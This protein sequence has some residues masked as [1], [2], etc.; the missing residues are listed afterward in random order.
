MSLNS[1]VLRR[2]R[3]TS[4]A[5]EAPLR[6]SRSDGPVR[7]FLWLLDTPLGLALMFAVALAVR[8]A[9]A[10]KYGFHGDL[11]LFQL[12]AIGLH[13]VGIRHFYVGYMQSNTTFVYPPGYLYILDVIAKISRVPDYRL[14]KLPAILG[15]LGLAW[16]AGVFALR[17]APEDLRRRLPVRGLVIA[18]VLFNPAVFALS[19]MWGQV[20]AVP[21]VFA[22][23]AL[24]L[25]LTG[26]H[27]VGR[28]T[29]AMVMFAIAFSM[30]PQSS[31]LAPVLAYALYRRY[32]YRRGRADQLRG[33][34]KVA[35]V[36][37]VGAVLWAVS[38]IPFGLSPSGLLSFYSKASN[39]Y[40]ITS[41]WAFNLWGVIGFQRGDVRSAPAL[42][43]YVAGIPA[44][45]VGAI[46][47]VAGT[48]YVLWRTH[49]SLNRGHDEARV[50]VVAAAMTSLLAFTLLTR[51]HERYLF[52]VI[53]GLAPLVLWRGFRR[54]YVVVS[55]LFILNLWYPFAVYNRSW[56]V[57]TLQFGRVFNW[58]FGNIDTTDTWQKKMWSVFMVAACVALVARG[59]RWIE[60]VDGDADAVDRA[61]AP[62][63]APAA[64]T[65]AAAGTG[66]GATGGG[67]GGGET[68]ETGETGD[69]GDT[70]G[71]SATSAA[72]DVASWLRL[73]RAGVRP[74]AEPSEPEPTRR[75]LR[76]L[77]LSLVIVSCVFSLVILRSETTPANNLNDSAFHLEMVRWASHQI[78]EG[79][80]PLDGWFPDLSLGSSFFHHY[81]SLP[82]T[83]T[84]YAA[85]IS[86]FDLTSTYLW[87]LYLML[88]L[89][90]ISVY[91]GARL[92]SLERW[93]A[94]AAALV[95]PLIVSIT[96][97]GYEHGSYTWQGLGVYTQLFG[98]W[99]LPLVWGLTWRAVNK[100]GKWY[101]PAAG[102]LALTIATHLMTGYLAVL[103]IG[104]WVLLARR[105]FFR[106]IGRAAVVA[107]GGL[108]TAA[109]V[110]VPLLADRNYAAQSELYKGK[111]FDDSYGAAKI[112]PWLFRGELFDHG[113]FPIFSLLLA[114]GFVVCVLRAQR[115]EAARAL[116][117]IWTFSLLLFFGRATW[118]VRSVVNLLPGNGDLQMHRFMSGVDLAGIFFAG[119]GLV[120]LA[121]LAGFALT[122]GIGL[123]QRSAAKPI[124]VW[125]AVTVAFVGILAPAWTERAHYDLR[126]S[127]FIPDQRKYEETDGV[128][129]AK[130]V[131]E[132]EKL[133]GGRIYAGTRAN[134]GSYYTIGS[135]QGFAEVEDY[136]A[137]SIGYP[138]RTVQSLSTDVD[139]TFADGDP[140]QYQIMNMMY[141]ILP[142]TMSPPVPATLLDSQGRHR[143]Y[144]VDTSGYFQ[145][146]DVMGSETSN[147]TD[148]GSESYNFRYSDLAMH[149]E[150]PSV[151][152]NGA[153]AAPPTV[154]GDVQPAGSPG[155]VI[156]Q[157]NDKENGLFYATVQ[158]NRTAGVLLK[159]SF[160]PRWTVTVDGI[161]QKPVMIAP[162]L[163]GVEV[164]AGRHVI[165]FHYKSYSH[166]PILV[167]IGGLTLLGLVLWPRRKR[168]L[169]R[170]RA[171]TDPGIGAGDRPGEPEVP[172]HDLVGDPGASP[173]SARE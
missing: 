137:D 2:R 25:L 19:T 154:S 5:P 22:L 146:I 130:L 29:F 84:A 67:G 139:A 97:Y 161:K 57:A 64:M 105:G 41:V 124:V 167:T 15:D 164:P 163:V 152:F 157:G 76:L 133:G 103:S 68:G 50:M 52:P 45:Y 16:L 44:F 36:G 169:G 115:S 92:L 32:L 48:A 23:A 104:V 65:A 138:F 89:W 131:K 86:P 158:A 94:A 38:G 31:F 136:D 46:A 17:L 160:D 95:S 54:V 120:A 47:F 61:P 172:T 123:I 114:V 111:F 18:A 13:D 153:P 75:W 126:D 83:L 49:L 117:G 27:S 21:A 33:L 171:S 135:V 156:K 11:N 10:Q 6:S 107:I 56:G 26:R 81:Q 60:R 59:F 79:R 166:Y 34:G 53:V 24:L 147:R 72:R 71:A 113:R 9:L 132:A 170:F 88:A 127:T 93:P 87:I 112:L 37:A 141:M 51:M 102:V 151:A 144:K 99:L 134:W 100:G 62:V 55:A 140:A 91:L 162:S 85:R 96:G 142:E 149:N 119:V 122:K 28:D 145:V 148:I 143:L 78:S 80:I 82:Y 125:T 58:V 116:L 35:C 109:W 106:R 101:A 155:T 39:G 128:G 30:K 150:Y 73:L 66:L 173:H 110:L 118:G 40:K 70:G 20:D 74:I 8:L 121:R 165:A 129:F 98:M 77:P 108:V 69:T 4:G 1:P 14:M 42:V 12:W 168:L 159:E 43:Q 3:I 63:L 7:H 90:P